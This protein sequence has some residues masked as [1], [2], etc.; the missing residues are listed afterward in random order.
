ML[1]A[2]YSSPV[3]FHAI[4]ILLSLFVLFKAAD[5]LVEGISGY[6]SRLGL[7]DALIGL[8]VV[9]TA[10]SAPEVISSLTGFM[11]GHG[12]VGFGAIM[13]S[14][15]VHVGF[16]LGI[17]AIVGRRTGLEAGIFSRQK[18]LMWGALM[19]PLLLALDG[20]L[21]RV[22]GVLLLLVFAFYVVHL[23]RIEGALG[24]LKK[25]VRLRYL[26][27]DALVFLGCLAAIL[28]SGRWLVFSSIGLAKE[29]G[30]PPYFIALTIIGIG[31]TM[32][33]IAVEL[34][35]LFKAHSA[36]GLGDLLGSLM[37]EF[38][39]FF[40]ILAVIHP[41]EV[42]IPTVLNAFVFLALSITTLMLLMRT[43]FLTW[44]HGFLFLSYYAVFLIIEICKIA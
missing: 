11:S 25:S 14:N 1:E 38:L 17:L 27:R 21:S 15:M 6:A 12:T 26:W 10:A 23:W 22:D 4:V 43:K 37:I 42:E 40:G 33:D 41:L 3:L 29:F 9:A 16:A 19:L 24:R 32:P 18:L 44:K 13:G 28:L 30:I 8:L 2:V 7:S 39:L 36:I 5:Y 20:M 31:T 34:R 35:S